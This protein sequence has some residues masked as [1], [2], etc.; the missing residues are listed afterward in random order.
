MQQEFVG[1]VNVVGVA[2]RDDLSPMQNFVTGN[3]VDA[4]PHLA[5]LEGDVW[6][7]FGV[8]S[9]PAFAFINDDG[10]VEI[11]IGAM[12]VDGLTERM[13]ALAAT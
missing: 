5:D 4:F 6:Q 3:G 13:T 8:G 7:A 1:Q 9:Q 12:G 2:G 10:T 11:V